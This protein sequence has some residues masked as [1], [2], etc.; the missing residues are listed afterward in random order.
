MGAFL[1]QAPMQKMELTAKIYRADP[2]CDL[3]GGTGLTIPGD[4]SSL[5]SCRRLIEDKGTIAVHYRRM[6]PRFK[7]SLRQWKGR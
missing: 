4:H 6:W 2:Q 3:C 1:S 7:A 5:C